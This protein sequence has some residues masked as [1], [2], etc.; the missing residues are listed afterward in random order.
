MKGLEIAN[1][2][3]NLIILFLINKKFIERLKNF[4]GS[5]DRKLI[6]REG[7]IE[8]DQCSQNSIVKFNNFVDVELNCFRVRTNE[9]NDQRV[10]VR[11]GNKN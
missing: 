3:H 4:R 10:N 9:Q 5:N 6:E 11:F 2:H 8:V 1:N 7:E